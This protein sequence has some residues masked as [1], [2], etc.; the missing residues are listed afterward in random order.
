MNNM[1]ESVS[2]IDKYKKLLIPYK[3]SDST[4]KIL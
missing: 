4:E 3:S 1:R 2:N